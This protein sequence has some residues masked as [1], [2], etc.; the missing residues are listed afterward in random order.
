MSEKWRPVVGYEGLYEVSDAGRVRSLDRADVRGR[1]ISGHVL[2]PNKSGPGLTHVSVSLHSATGA[3]NTIGVQ[4]LVLH[5]FVGPCPKGMQACHNDG[6]GFNNAVGNLRWDTPSNNQLDRRKHGTHRCGERSPWAK[7]SD[8]QRREIVA[9]LRGGRS[10]RSVAKQFG[11]A[12][13]TI[14]HIWYVWQR[15]EVG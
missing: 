2:R 3:R 9:L 14:R 6:N 12:H 7:L 4:R 1:R 13:A 15:Y 8:A 5:A 10:K 11:V